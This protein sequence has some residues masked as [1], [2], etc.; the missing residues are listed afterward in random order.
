MII[1]IISDTHGTLQKCAKQALYGVDRIVHAGDIGSADVIASL[2]QIAP[3]TAIRGNMD[4]G[5]WSQHLPKAEMIAVNGLHFYVIHDLFNLDLDPCAAGV[6]AVI[7]GHTHRAEIKT[8]QGVLYFNPGSASWPR[9]GGSL[10]IG[11][12]EVDSKR[13][14]PEIV[15]LDG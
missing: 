15:E 12:I 8:I 9:S 14:Y 11:R 4:R 5:Q 10:S 2:E 13:L 6:N 1:G 3:V 7:S